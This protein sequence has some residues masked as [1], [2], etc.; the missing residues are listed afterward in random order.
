MIALGKLRLKLLRIASGRSFGLI[1]WSLPA[2]PW[3]DAQ[4]AQIAT[5]P[6]HRTKP[7]RVAILIGSL[8]PSRKDHTSPAEY[9]KAKPRYRTAAP[10]GSPA[11]APAGCVAGALPARAI[12]IISGGET[13]TPLA[14]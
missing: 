12:A 9:G 5:T 3:S 14:S 2:P 8:L 4:P 13:R 10:A 6:T 1:V 11:T 7:T